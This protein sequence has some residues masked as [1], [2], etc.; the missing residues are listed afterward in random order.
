MSDSIQKLGELTRGIVQSAADIRAKDAEIATLTSALAAC[1]EQL[2]ASE[3]RAS[4]M[5]R[6]AQAAEA[7]RDKHRAEAAEERAGWERQSNM[8]RDAAMSVGWPVSGPTGGGLTNYGILQRFTA[9][10]RAAS[11][12][13]KSMDIPNVFESQA[14]RDVAHNRF[15]RAKAA[16]SALLTESAVGSEEKPT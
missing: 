16:L 5:H 11:A 10:H 3:K 4:E 8:I 13:I 2:A 6:R 15:K 12:V 1:R 14:E 9:L 7:E